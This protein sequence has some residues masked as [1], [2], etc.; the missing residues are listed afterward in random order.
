M[1]LPSLDEELAGIRDRAK[2]AELAEKFGAGA[3]GTAPGMPDVQGAV[4][5]L[6]DSPLGKMGEKLR[7]TV[8][9]VKRLPKNVGLGMLDAAVN[10]ANFVND[11]LD[12]AGDHLS[13]EDKSPAALRDKAELDYQDAAYAQAKGLVDPEV[14]YRGWRDTL[15]SDDHL[16]DSLTQG[17]AQFAI[18]FMAWSRAAGVANAGSK[19]ATV[20]RA[21]AA[22][23]ATLATAYAPHDPRIADLAE[24][25]RHSEGRLG[26]A[27]RTISPDGSLVN[28]Y[29]NYMTER[30]GE[31]A[32]EGRFKN[33]IDGLVGSAATAALLKTGATALKAARNAPEVIGGAQLKGPLAKQKG[34]L[35]LSLVDSEPRHVPLGNVA[36]SHTGSVLDGEFVVPGS[37]VL[38]A[39]AD[40]KPVGFIAFKEAD[41][42]SLQINRTKVADENRGQGLGKKLLMDALDY[43]EKVGRPLTSDT[44]VTVAQLR[45]YEA[46]QRAGKIKVTY[47]DPTSVQAALATA[48]PRVPVKGKGGKPVVTKIERVSQE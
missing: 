13:P 31:T 17:V 34:M 16:S 48:D 12:T 36:D 20:T 35:D 38:T 22:E 10:T 25:G 14:A 43:A 3:A 47:S 29:I 44:S 24:L 28:D 33:T 19:L 27:L 26:D 9:W 11:A 6:A 5:A 42:G 41:D 30:D 8:G 23:A 37:Q 2:Q 4:G 46:L 1:D 15:R 18:P 39:K 40:G 45:V 7:D 21:S 32:M